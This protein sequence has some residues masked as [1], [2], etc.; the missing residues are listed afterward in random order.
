MGDGSLSQDEIDALLQGTDDVISTPD[1]APPV[2]VAQ[3]GGALSPIERDSLADLLNASMEVVVPSLSGYLGK[4]INISSALIEVKSQ[5]D[6]R[7]DFTKQYVQL[8]VDYTDG[9]SGKNLILFNNDD[10][11]IISS[12][13]MGDET[14]APSEELTEAHQST[15][16]EFVS[17]MLSSNATEFSNRFG[18]S[19]GV[20]APV[21][22]IVNDA[23]QLQLPPGN[24]IAKITY[25]FS[26]EGLVNSKFYHLMELPLAA[27]LARSSMSEIQTSLPP[28]QTDQHGMQSGGQVGVSQ[29]KFPPLGDGVPYASGGNISLLLDVPMNMT[30]ELGRTRQLVKDILGLGEGSIIELDKLAGEPVDLLVNGKLIAKGEVVVIDENFGVRVTDIVSPAERLSKIQ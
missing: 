29:V 15:I 18:R 25:N 23:S 13:M 19:V 12:L 20:S 4:S 10:A 27:D 28:Q 30:V 9:F 3:R 2:D 1:A 16:Q 5:N 7:S 24:E 14:G 22:S 17:Q 26:I 6:V 21:L 11:G 8:S